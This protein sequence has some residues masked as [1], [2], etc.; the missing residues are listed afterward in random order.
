[1]TRWAHS[2]FGTTK[3]PTPGITASVAAE[4]GAAAACAA[5]GEV[6]AS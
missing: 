3:C 6:M 2:D 1:M 5:A 4:S